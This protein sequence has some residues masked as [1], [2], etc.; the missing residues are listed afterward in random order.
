MCIDAIA[1]SLISQAPFLRLPGM[2]KTKKRATENNGSG[3]NV[4]EYECIREKEREREG[5]YRGSTQ[6]FPG[7]S[8]L[9]RRS[10]SRFQCP[11]T[12]LPLFTEK[13]ERGR[14]KALVFNGLPLGVI[15]IIINYN[16]VFR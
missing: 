9:C 10:H 12:C 2:R 5:E 6:Y 8:D 13:R 15:I 4:R 7:Y 16:Y 1:K 3:M 14:N 11:S